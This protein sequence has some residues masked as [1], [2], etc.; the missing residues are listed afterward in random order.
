MTNNLDVLLSFLIFNINNITMIEFLL[1]IKWY[2]KDNI[3]IRNHYGNTRHMRIWQLTS[4]RVWTNCQV[5]ISQ[6]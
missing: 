2:L 4:I 1:S 5:H 3:N 6:V